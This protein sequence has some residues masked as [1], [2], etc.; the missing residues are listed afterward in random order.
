M[1]KQLLAFAL[2]FLVFGI[3]AQ[4]VRINEAVS[5]NS[6]FLDEDGDS[7]DWFELHNYGSTPV[8]LLNWAITDD[9]TD[10][11]MWTFPDLMLQPDEYLM[12]WASKKDRKEITY[13]R[14]LV[15]RGDIF[16]YKIPTT[17]IVQWKMLSFDDNAWQQGSTGFGYSDGDDATVLPTGTKSVFLRKKFNVSDISSLSKLILDI[18]FDD[19]FVAYIN[20]KEIARENING[21]PPAYNSG[22]IVDHEAKIYNGGRPD[23]FIV[24]SPQ[25]LLNIGENILSIQLHNISTTSSDMTLIPFLT[26]IFT[27]SNTD[28]VTPPDILELY[29]SN[30]HTNFKISSKSETL[31]LSNDEGT[32]IDELFIE[33]L[34]SDVSIGTSVSNGNLV[35]YKNPTPGKR[36]GDEEFLGTI[37][38]SVS[39]SH[40]GGKVDGE[41]TLLLSG[42]VDDEV[43]RFTTDATEPTETSSIYNSPISI[44]SNTVIRARI[45]KPNYISSLTNSKTFLFNVSH[46]LPVVTLVTDPY[47]LFDNDYGIYVKGD[48]YDTDIPYWG[49][50]FWEDWERPVQFSLYTEDGNLGTEFNAGIKIFGGWSR[51]NEQRSLSI[52]ARGQYGTSE[53][54][55]PLFPQQPYDKY[56]A[57]VLRNSGNDWLN[58]MIRDAS[59]TS[60]MEGADIEFQDHRSTVTYINGEYW[61]IYNLR[62]KVNEHFLASKKN[63]DADLIDLLELDGQI[64]EGDNQEYLSLIDFITNNSLVTDENYNNV[65]SQIDIDNFVL[66]QVAQI[67]FNNTD[68][69][70]N[71]IKYWKSPGGK[72]RW[73]LYDT[74]FGFGIWNVEDYRHDALSFALE[75]DGPNWPNP[76]WSTLLFR[77]LIE[78]QSFR[79]KFI[80]RFA[81]E[82][83]TRFLSNNVN[84]HIQDN[85]DVITSE[86]PNHYDR[87]GADYNASNLANMKLFAN[88]RS[89]YV[90]FHIRNKFG[91]TNN[92]RLTLLN[93]EIE[94]GF[95]KVNNNLKIQSSYW[96]GD[97]FEN[98]PVTLKAIAESG[99][100]FSHWSGDNESTNIEIELSM[101]SVMSVKAHFVKSST[102][103]IPIVI[104]EINYKSGDSVDAGD[105]IELYNPN[106]NP[107]DIS[108]WIFKD[109]K[110]SNIFIIPDGTSIEGNGYLVVTKNNAD[111]I[112]A[113]PNVKNFIGDFGFG[114]SGSGDAVRIFNDSN[115]LQD[116]VYYE[117]VAPWPT[118]A[119]GQGPSL[120]LKSPELDNT[121]PESWGCLSDYGSPGV[122]NDATTDI[123]DIEGLKLSF[124]PNPIDDYLYVSGLTENVDVRIYDI[125]GQLI[126]EKNIED[127]IYLKNLD[128]GVYIIEIEIQNYK[129]KQKIIKD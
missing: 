46:D 83:N 2:S 71:N 72:W 69:P 5:S 26:A 118:C 20:G 107:L 88:N 51:V 120:E 45:F 77:K 73:I 9:V 114:L 102:E 25:D 35:Y 18:D 112:V 101:I 33:G 87:W 113:F 80:N 127:K 93:D 97:Y 1:K 7:P 108:N 68:W 124:Y 31:T 30:L 119:N 99:F 57:V 125:K 43:I 98:I 66:Y 96:V 16:K 62:E 84:S 115:E 48:S 60:L 90:R 76:A 44:S 105:W 40:Q 61:G 49:A 75:E 54:D 6:I 78:N 122:V 47:N 109:S 111:F 70:G 104:T 3:D 59:L 103:I 94:K 126:I 121:L 36:N 8:S 19:A 27:D 95:I 32:V 11:T 81:D 56:Q 38:S 23:R 29:N 117:S 89:S 41:F 42:S 79:N 116:E 39:F 110:D 58:T 100:E 14:T 92:K 106:K 37:T 128:S 82:L 52:F 53:I 21:T 85:F 64:I 10:L 12:V 17:E 34:F 63:V 86:V 28:G 55:Y 24:D 65:S 123:E 91:I 13:A 4:E 15:N 74:D 22:T 129:F 67:Y 50:N